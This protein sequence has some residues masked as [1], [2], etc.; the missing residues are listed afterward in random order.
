MASRPSIIAC[1][2]RMAVLAMGMKFLVGPVIM[3]ASAGITL[4]RGTL[5]KVSIVQVL[6]FLFSLV[7][8]NEVT[9]LNNVCILQAALPQGIVP[10]VF[11]K[12]YDVHPDMLST[13]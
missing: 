5:F 4:S 1:G 8:Q 2:T 3:T 13:G 11:A 10:F 7:V 9:I 12:E 6:E